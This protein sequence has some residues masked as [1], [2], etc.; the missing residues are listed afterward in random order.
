MQGRVAQAGILSNF[1]LNPLSV[2]R[3]AKSVGGVMDLSL[4]RCSSLAL[5]EL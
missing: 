3:T 4:S 5:T 1:R 2:S